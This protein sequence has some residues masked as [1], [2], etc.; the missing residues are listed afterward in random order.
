MKEKQL[1]ANFL[2]VTFLGLI[3]KPPRNESNYFIC[4]NKGLIFDSNGFKTMTSAFCK[5]LGL[6]QRVDMVV[7]KCY[8]SRNNWLNELVFV[9][10]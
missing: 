5:K 3:I 9:A 6:M 10:M 2:I 7:L 8:I 4:E 1:A